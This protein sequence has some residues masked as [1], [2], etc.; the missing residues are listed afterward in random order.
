VTLRNS[1]LKCV[2]VKTGVMLLENGIL[3]L[4]DVDSFFGDDTLHHH[5]HGHF[6][7]TSKTNNEHFVFV[8]LRN[9][10]TKLCQN[11]W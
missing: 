11:L 5:F 10:Q 4:S 8:H 2:R 7:P 9:R 1:L 3:L 6:V